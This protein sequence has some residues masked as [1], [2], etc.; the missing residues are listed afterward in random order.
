MLVKLDPLKL[1]PVLFEMFPI[2][3]TNELSWIPIN[4]QQSKFQQA[5]GI[6]L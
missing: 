1:F 6:Y 3:Y 5:V 2:R 4:L